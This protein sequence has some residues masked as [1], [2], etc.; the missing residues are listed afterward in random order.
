MADNIGVRPSTTTGS[1]TVAT[2][3]VNNVH[4]PIYKQGYGL[5]GTTPVSVS[6]TNPLPVVDFLI[7]V[8]KGNIPGHSLIHKFAHN[9]DVD[10][11]AVEDVWD[12]GGVYV[13]LTSGVQFE[14]V[15]TSAN[16]DITGTQARKIYIELIKEDFTEATEEL[17]LDG[18]NPV[19][20]TGIDYIRCNR[21]YI[22]EVGT[23]DGTN[24][25]S[26]TIRVVS[27]GATQATIDAGLGQTHKSHY[28]VPAGKTGYLIRAT[29]SAD[30]NKNSNFYLVQRQNPNGVA[31]PYYAH[32]HVHEWIG[33]VEPSETTFKANHTFPE[34]TDVWFEAIA[35]ANNT[36]V[37][38]N[39]DLLLVDNV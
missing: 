16:D 30:A 8:N 3:D 1:V 12:T 39:Y 17:E 6:Q 5:D 29:V 21:A 18:L 37:E 13:P 38:V 31:A 11:S 25:G 9:S 4:Y 33:V 35:A 2:D 27:A 22:T 32:R 24:E 23:Y 20:T 7:E 19:T 34:K 14:V 36:L 26:I 10:T 28:T 15:S